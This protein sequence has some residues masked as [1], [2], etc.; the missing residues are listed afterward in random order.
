[1]PINYEHH[2]LIAYAA[3]I[4]RWLSYP[5]RQARRLMKE[6]ASGET[7][8]E[9]RESELTRPVIGFVSESRQSADNWRKVQ[10][11]LETLAQVTS[12]I[13]PNLL[14]RRVRDLAQV[15]GLTREDVLILEAW[16]F[17]SESYRIQRML[18]FAYK[19]DFDQYA[20]LREVDINNAR[21]PQAL[22][23]N[24]EAFRQRFDPDAPLTRA[25]L[26]VLNH[27]LDISIV[28]RLKRLT[29]STDEK[30]DVRELL[31]GKSQ[32]TEL[33]W[34]DFDHLGRMHDDVESILR[35]AAQRG[36][37]GV[38]IL[39]HGPPGTGKTT[40]CQALAERTGVRLF[41][42]GEANE[43]GLEPAGDERLAELCLAQNLL[44][45]DRRAVLLLDEMQDILACHSMPE[46]LFP[47]SGRRWRGSSRVFLN[48]LLERT[49]VPTLWTTTDARHVDSSILRRMVFAVEMR[50]PPPRIRAGIWSRQLARHGIEASAAQARSLAVEFDATPGVAEGA[51]A[52]GELGSG[53]F[54]MVRRSV[55][56]LSRVLRCYRPAAG[57]GAV[58]FD[59]KL[60]NTDVDL[61]DLAD[62]LERGGERRLSLCLQGPPGTGKSAF[63]RYLA[64]RMD[65]DV[66]HRRASDLF[67]MYVGQSERNIAEAFAEARD[68]GAFLVF[69]EADSL[70]ADRRG[71][72]RIWEISQVNEMLTWMESHPL[73]FACT[74]NFAKRLDGATLR[75]FIFKITLGYLKPDGAAAAFRKW[76]ALSPPPG[77]AA[78]EVLTPGDFEVVRRKAQVLGQLDDAQALLAMLRAECAAKPGR[79]KAIGFADR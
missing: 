52:A 45:E 18:L 17:W 72:H 14:A 6:V 3:N 60:L 36:A 31:L 32:T 20:H 74:T 19:G 41:G 28:D 71:A 55:K 9:V 62:R 12:E 25:G 63:V 50:L 38:N 67:D 21:L 79:V 5:S 30:A 58:D 51:A 39:V 15:L 2:L 49:P 76:F 48:R 56:G 78:L 33:S 73:P 22:G 10:N 77:L 59:P 42:V 61:A 47:E 75:R 44:G 26:I 70:L 66:V 11:A 4:A 23:M 57:A 65:L 64:G 37:R 8:A 68:N 24:V 35:G 40:F 46:W 1:M 34:P 69:D 43:R 54:D 16:L 13:G 53:G 27:D 7:F 29:L